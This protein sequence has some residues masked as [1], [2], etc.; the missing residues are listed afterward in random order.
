MPIVKMLAKGQVVI[1]REI[2]EA[3]GIVAGAKLHVRIEG[4]EIVL[5]PLPADPIHAIVWN[6]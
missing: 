6:V 5:Y 2:R 1:P 3:L 4:K